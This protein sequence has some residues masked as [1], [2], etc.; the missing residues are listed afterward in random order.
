M[1]ELFS[2]GCDISLKGVCQS[3]TFAK[4]TLLY[5]ETK[6]DYGNSTVETT[7]R[8]DYFTRENLP[9]QDF[10]VLIWTAGNPHYLLIDP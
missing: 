10:R 6:S 4:L 5:R 1:R 7:Y 8:G 9:F 3:L 2:A